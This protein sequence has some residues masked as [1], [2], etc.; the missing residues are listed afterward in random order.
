MLLML[1][2]KCKNNLVLIHQ[3]LIKYIHEKVHVIG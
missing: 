1:Q 2:K 3:F